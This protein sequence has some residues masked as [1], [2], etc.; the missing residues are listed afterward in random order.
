MSS[1]IICIKTLTPPVKV[2]NC[3]HSF[4]HSCVEGLRLTEDIRDDEGNSLAVSINCPTCRQETMLHERGIEFLPTNYA[5]NALLTRRQ[6]AI[7]NENSSNNGNS[8]NGKQTGQT[9]SAV[10]R[11]FDRQERY[12]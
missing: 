11:S 8:L 1:C 5:L 12:A 2:L 6:N 7:M 9:L 10:M 4:C 3:G